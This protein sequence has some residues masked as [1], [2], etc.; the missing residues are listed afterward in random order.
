MF[1]LDAYRDFGHSCTLRALFPGQASE[2]LATIDRD[3][4]SNDGPD[5]RSRTQSRHLDSAALAKLC[6]SPSI[7][8]AVHD[9]LGPHIVLWRS[10]IF[11]K[12]PG[13]P[14][15]PWH[16]DSSIWRDLLTPMV[17]VTAWVALT[18]TTLSNGCIEFIPGSHRVT[19]RN[20][21][22]NQQ[23]PQLP[24]EETDRSL[25]IPLEPGQ[26]ILFDSTTL[27]RS[28]P[29]LSNERR[30]GVAIRFTLP[31]VKICQ[32]QRLFDGYKSISI[33]R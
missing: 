10:N 27:H 29:N 6:N 3:V 15:L 23:Y 31:T 14:E 22:F 16:R 33:Q 1:D 17:N 32:D 24:E 5:V 18:S 25:S 4:L 7:T 12:L 26:F 30:L 8:S 9:V 11:N 21:R 19:Y 13:A 28:G 20:E 2:L